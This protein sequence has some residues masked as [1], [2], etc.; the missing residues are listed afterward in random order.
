MLRRCLRRRWCRR[1]PPRGSQ[2]PECPGHGCGSGSGRGSGSRVRGHALAN[3]VADQGQTVRA[4]PPALAAGW[5][6]AETCRGGSRGGEGAAPATARAAADGIAA[7]AVAAAAIAAAAA[8][9]R[10]RVC[11]GARV[12]D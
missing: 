8:A 11:P 5:S 12:V 6:D 7:A 4:A 1:A 10:C 3:A 2:R 9:A